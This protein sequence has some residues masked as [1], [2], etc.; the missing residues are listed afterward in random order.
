MIQVVT[1]SVLPFSL[2]EFRDHVRVSDRDHDP[3]LRRALYAAAVDIENKAGIRLRSSTLYDY[4]RGMPEPF[5]F[6]AGPVNSVSA[7]RN[8]T[9]AADVVATAYELDL[10][11]GWPTLRSL[12]GSA[13][14]STKTYRVTYAAGYASIPA[15]LQVAVFELAAM[16]FE[17]R[18]A[19][20]PVQMY[21]LPLSINSILQGYGPRGM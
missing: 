4:F 15:P 14:N 13:W 7:V 21:A 2:D 18:E 11:G 10:V 12:S 19:A 16:H 17:N 5:R 3:A 8:M 9:D 20:T 1:E 6:S